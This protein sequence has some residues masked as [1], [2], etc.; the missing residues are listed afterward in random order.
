MTPRL[1]IDAG[2]LTAQ[3]RDLRVGQG[4]GPAGLRKSLPSSLSAMLTWG[5]GQTVASVSA[6][7]LNEEI[8]LKVLSDAEWSELA[9]PLATPPAPPKG[10]HAPKLFHNSPLTCARMALSESSG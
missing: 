5:S 3:L 7:E 2:V 9:R 1:C 8:M 6:E 4:S 10:Q